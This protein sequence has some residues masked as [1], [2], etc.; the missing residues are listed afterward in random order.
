MQS[1]YDI[2]MLVMLCDALP[3]AALI[4]N[5]LCVC[6][7]TLASAAMI[8]TSYNNCGIVFEFTPSMGYNSYSEADRRQ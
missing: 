7:R 1:D 8:A 4:H 3:Y 2:A 5:A 6:K